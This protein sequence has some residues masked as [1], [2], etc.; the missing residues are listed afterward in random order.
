MRQTQHASTNKLL[1]AGQTGVDPLPVTRFIEDGAEIN[2]S[3]WRPTEE[4][5]SW[6]VAG[7]LV[8]LDVL[9]MQPPVR[10]LVEKPRGQA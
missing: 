7:G 9:H 1:G 8:V 6:L 10:V 2:R 4:E 3:F 5:L